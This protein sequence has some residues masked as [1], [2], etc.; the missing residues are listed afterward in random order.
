MPPALLLM[1]SGSAPAPE[2]AQFQERHAKRV[3]SAQTL[4]PPPAAAAAAAAAEQ[5]Q[6]RVGSGGGA[7]GS[8]DAHRRPLGRKQSPA[9]SIEQLQKHP[10][11]RFEEI[12]LGGGESGGG[13][14]GGEASLSANAST[15]WTPRINLAEALRAACTK[16]PHSAARPSRAGAL[17]LPLAGGDEAIS[18]EEA[19]AIA[20]H[21]FGFRPTQPPPPPPPARSDAAEAV[22]TVH[23]SAGE[24]DAGDGSTDDAPAVVPPVSFAIFDDGLLESQ[25]A[26]ASAL[27]VSDAAAAPSAAFTI[28]DDSAPPPPPPDPAPAAFA[29]FEEHKEISPAPPPPPP[30]PPANLDEPRRPLAAQRTVDTPALPARAAG[31]GR[32]PLS[33]H[34]GS[35]PP[36]AAPPHAPMDT[37]RPMVTSRAKPAGRGGLSAARRP[38][39]DPKQLDTPRPN[40][41]AARTHHPPP[42]VL[43]R[44]ASSLR[45]SPDEAAADDRFE[46]TI[47]T[48]AALADL[49]PCFTGGGGGEDEDHVAATAPPP[50]PP[51]P[52][53]AAMPIIVF[54]EDPTEAPPPLPPL[55]AAA[56]PIVVFDDAPAPP[57]PPPPTG[58]PLLSGA[59]LYDARAPS[60]F[61]D[62]LDEPTCRGLLRNLARI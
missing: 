10:L 51:P 54:D 58:P 59:T 4:Y 17:P 38:P 19:R 24:V 31:G 32:A 48:K 39:L 42:T 30:P 6:R 62:G 50:P 28:F 29:I 11:A 61:D 27:D 15:P 49:L 3:L 20:R 52:P 41:L 46:M 22:P 43:Q 18:Y 37:P 9:V 33:A 40:A 16:T 26:E 21:G 14:E 56:A 13:A 34:A 36:L 25:G 44:R 60:L 55:P 57:P 45:A 8:A 7:H 53:A 23:T 12:A 2:Q 35:A 5:H 47:N 1:V